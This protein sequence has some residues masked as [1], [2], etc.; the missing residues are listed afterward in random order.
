MGCHPAPCLLL[1]LGAGTLNFVLAEPFDGAI[2]M[3]FV[4]VVIGIEIY[5]EHKTENALVAL[6]DL[7][8]PRVLVLRDGQRA[9]IPGR[10]VVRGDY[11][12]LAEGDRV[13]ADAALVQCV[14]V[15][16]DESTLTGESV[17][18]RKAECDPSA[19][20]EVMGRPGGDD[21]PWLFS[22]TLVVKGQGIAVVKETGIGTELRRIGTALRTIEP[23]R[24]TLQREIDRLVWITA[25]L[26]I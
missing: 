21:S 12:L 7:S 14:N 1:L 26:G 13:P 6:R 5:Q 4:L 10:D 20:A 18:V 25:P 3:L 15:A 24:T 22:G 9:R 8:S 17:P 19:I 11:V 23:E 2:L 16:V